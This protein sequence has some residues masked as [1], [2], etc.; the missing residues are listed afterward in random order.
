MDYTGKSDGE[1]LSILEGSRAR[2]D[3]VVAARL[4]FDA[5]AAEAGR[6]GLE[7]DPKRARAS[8]P[9]AAAG[10]WT[11]AR[12]EG[13]LAPFIALTLT[14]PGNERHRKAGTGFT[15]AGGL[16]RK[17]KA[18]IASYTGVKRGG[19]NAILV[20]Y[21]ERKGEMPI[22]AL[23]ADEGAA[24]SGPADEDTVASVLARAERTFTAEQLQTE[25]LPL[26]QAIVA[27][28]RGEE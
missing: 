18:H 10:E 8:R 22:F 26:W 24:R 15:H 27:R 19:V 13:A 17:G 14:V 9:R 2:K 1:L 25:A 16:K 6:R 20:A 7:T 21:V 3:R 28:A 23:H 4:V 5:A 12:V 11:P